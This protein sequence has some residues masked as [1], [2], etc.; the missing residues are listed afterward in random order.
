[1]YACHI[2]VCSCHLSPTT[3]CHTYFF[4]WVRAAGK[5]I[6]IPSSLAVVKYAGDMGHVDR[7]DKG[8]A[9]SRLR[10]KRCKKR[11]HRVLGIWELAGVN[12]NIIVLFGEIVEDIEELKKSK[13]SAALGYR[14]W[15]QNQLGNV[16][17][18]YGLRKAEE[19][20]V[21][22]SACVVNMF[23]RR[24]HLVIRRQRIR[25]QIRFGESDTH[26]LHTHT[27][28]IPEFE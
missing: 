26:N 20:W 5:K 4:R 19:Q 14:H 1:M 12:N 25:E 13:E 17:I 21:H 2:S 3:V 11:Y 28:S 23:M 8:V 10:L 27:T 15:F 24:C 16:I 7:F 9:L 22:L 18:D 6:P